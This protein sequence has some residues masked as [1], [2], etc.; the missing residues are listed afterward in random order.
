[1]ANSFALISFLIFP[2][3][4]LL[5]FRSLRLHSAIIWTMMLGFLFLPARVGIDLPG[6]P[7]LEKN[8]IPLLSVIA[9]VLLIGRRERLQIIPPSNIGKLLVAMLLIGPFLTVLTNSDQMWVGERLL[10]ATRPYDALSDGV[11]VMIWLIPFIVGWSFFKQ[12]EEQREIVRIILVVGL[13]Y[14]VLMLFEV[15]FSPQL[16]RWV[17]GFFQHSFAQQH[18][19]GGFR[20][21]VF[22]K[23]GLWVAFFAMFVLICAGIMWR[24]LAQGA[25]GLYLYMIGYLFAVLV[26][27]KSLASLAYGLFLLP[28]VMFASPRQQIRVALIL[29]I[30][31]ITYPAIRGAGLFPVGGIMSVANTIDSNRAKSLAFRFENED[32]L[33]DRAQQRPLFGWGGWGRN[34]VY[35]TNTGKDLSTTDGYWIVVI[36]TEGW[37]GFIARFGMFVLPIFLVWWTVRS[38]PRLEVS[39]F[40]SGLCLLVAINLIEFLPNST[41]PPITRL[42]AGSLVGYALSV[43]WM[44][45]REAAKQKLA[46][47]GAVGGPPK[48]R[49]VI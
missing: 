39:P 16:H 27:C 1:M 49:T 24:S 11:S 33:L 5:L 6:L 8:S 14:S 30:V 31:S 3:V 15:R 41:S 37:F 34:R 44:E 35:D 42:M 10:S 21:V 46:D 43:R 2:I 9:A 29:A 45:R 40:T 36:G 7:A 38:R 32:M 22:L 18:R 25:K 26:L 13:A 23:H 28:L 12:A 20:P 47:Q 19:G 48:Q 4:A 17:Y